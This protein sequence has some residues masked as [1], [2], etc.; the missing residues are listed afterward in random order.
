MV[1]LS[2]PPPLPKK[3]IYSEVAKLGQVRLF[4]WYFAEVVQFIFDTI[5]KLKVQFLRYLTIIL[6]VFK[7]KFPWTNSTAAFQHKAWFPNFWFI[8]SIFGSCD[9]KVTVMLG[10]CFGT[11][12][13]L[14]LQHWK[15]YATQKKYLQSLIDKYKHARI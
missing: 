12:I 7:I 2:H 4:R 11:Q 14:F 8:F 9:F 13:F 10:N 1:W 5:Y 6:N 3:K 15:C